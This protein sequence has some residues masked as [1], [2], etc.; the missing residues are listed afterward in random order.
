MFHEDPRKW[1]IHRSWT[2]WPCWH[3]RYL[4]AWWIIR[5]T[6]SLHRAWQDG[7]DYGSRKE[8]DRIIV[9]M[10]DID[11]QRKNVETADANLRTAPNL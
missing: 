5:G 1:K 9:N 8:Y 2:G 10:G 7:L 3:Q 6:W 11:A 4:E